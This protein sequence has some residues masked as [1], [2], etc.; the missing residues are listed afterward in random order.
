MR[1]AAAVGTGLRAPPARRPF[2]PSPAAPG[3]GFR[4]FRPGFWIGH[5]GFS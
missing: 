2:F 3:P 1:K 5:P 4:F